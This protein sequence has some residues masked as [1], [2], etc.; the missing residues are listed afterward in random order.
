MIWNIGVFITELKRV[1]QHNAV[2]YCSIPTKNRLQKGTK[3][4]G[5]IYLEDELKGFFQING[6]KYFNSGYQNGAVLYCKAICQKN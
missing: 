2:F 3:I 5:D 1:L 6:F 4:Q